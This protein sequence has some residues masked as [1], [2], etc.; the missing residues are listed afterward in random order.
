MQLEANL[1][2][3]LKPSSKPRT[4]SR[5][6]AYCN[7]KML[8]M[9][10]L[11]F[12]SGLPLALIGGTLQ[13][14]FK[15]S[16]VDIVTIGFLAL[17]GQPYSYKYLWAPFMD[18]YVP[19][20]LGR[21]RGWILIAQLAIVCLLIAMTFFT[22]TINPMILGGLGLILAFFSA[23]Q[24]IAIDA[25][26]VD[27]LTPDERGLGAALGVEGYRLAMLASGGLALILADNIGWQATYLIMSGFM[28]IG[29]VANLLAKEP[30]T[31]KFANENLNLLQTIKQSFGDFFIRDKA[32]WFLVLIILYK[33]GD[34]FSH[35]LST[36]FLLDIGFSL[37]AVGTINKVVGLIASLIGVFAG[38]LLMTQMGL[39]R[40]L[41]LFGVLQAV[42]NL[43]FMLLAMVG[44][45][46]YL[47]SGAFF[48]ESLCGGMGT[49]A[50]VALLMSLC[51][52][53]YTA[54]QYALLSSFAALGR[55]Y[56]GPASGYMV[57][58]LGWTNFHLSTAIIAIPGL[59]LLVKLK[60]Y[61]NKV[62]KLTA[63]P[64]K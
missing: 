12:S 31:D 13:A 6:S 1:K 38:G 61:I 42:T 40:S 43:F 59:I 57:K 14:W 19:P 39:F 5:L 28:I 22:P 10:L 34:A 2:S 20:F 62:D 45:N 18:R 48:I 47:A 17:V 37:T 50:F 30:E 21:R 63:S 46:Y 49:A 53:K 64:S 52:T 35:A 33:L 8:I 25:Y 23:S 24:D 27:V 15:T 60:D 51:T 36:T 7:R 58:S 32:L 55:V 54:T 26:R 3:R 41:L 56:V 44:K 16:G 4:P 9:L 29:I 11:G